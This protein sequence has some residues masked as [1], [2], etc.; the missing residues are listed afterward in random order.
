MPT[1]KLEA[2]GP[3]LTGGLVQHKWKGEMICIVLEAEKGIQ[4]R[5]VLEGLFICVLL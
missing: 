1:E 4:H 3:A 5:R 2:R